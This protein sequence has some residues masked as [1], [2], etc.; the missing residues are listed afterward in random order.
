MSRPCPYIGRALLRHKV[1]VKSVRC[2]GC[3]VE[4]IER[5]RFKCV[6]CDDYDLC[7]GCKEKGLHPGHELRAESCITIFSYD[8]EKNE[9]TR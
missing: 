8:H 4:P 1:F 7:G 6:T 9:F 3:G 2:D 5:A